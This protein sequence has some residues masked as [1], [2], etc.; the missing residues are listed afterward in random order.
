MQQNNL[1]ESRKKQNNSK[2]IG[3]DIIEVAKMRL[4]NNS[5][6]KTKK[7]VKSEMTMNRDELQ[8][9]LRKKK[10]VSYTMSRSA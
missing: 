10:P 1:K 2:I 5:P 8:Y 6:E 7:G 9:F 4:H 3:Q